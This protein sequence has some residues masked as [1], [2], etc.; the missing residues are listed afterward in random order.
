MVYIFL[1]YVGLTGVLSFLFPL[2]LF[3]AEFSIDVFNSA[4]L[5]IRPFLV[6]CEALTIS[7]FKLV[8]GQ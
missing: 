4:R 1:T 7:N 5:P 6:A 8:E 2:L 3:E